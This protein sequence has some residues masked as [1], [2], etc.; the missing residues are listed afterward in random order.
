MKIIFH[1][2]F[3]V[4]FAVALVCGFGWV[5]AALLFGVLVHELSHAVVAGFFGV[6]TDCIRLLPFGAEISVDCALLS[7]DKKVI[8]LLS[9]ALG[10]IT[11]AIVLSSFLWLFPHFFLVIEVLIV[12]NAVP[13]ILNL[14]PIYPL[15]GGK[16]L[17]LVAG[18][19]RWVIWW[20]NIFF[21]GLFVASCLFFFSV[22]LLLMC[23]MMIICI[24]FELKAT[25]YTL[26]IKTLNKF[27]FDI[28]QNSNIIKHEKRVKIENNNKVEAQN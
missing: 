7:K 5:A 25:N 3:W 24:N 22:A 2:L 23:A 9:G 20:S 17:F 4:V 27:C 26:Y 15:D 21:G 8:V 18:E 6:R 14:L 11:V 28:A 19:K 13:G 10:N 1:P 16:I 12:A